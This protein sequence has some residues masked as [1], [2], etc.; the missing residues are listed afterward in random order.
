M[1]KA[2][3][4]NGAFPSF[5]EGT[6]MKEQKKKLKLFVIDD[7]D[8]FRA[9]LA[10]ILGREKEEFELAGCGK[11]SDETEE[12]CIA[13][14]PDVLLVHVPERETEGRLHVIDRIKDGVE[15]ARVLVI[16]EAG[17]VN[18]LLKIAAS[19]CD[20][21]V[22]SD[23]SET[24]LAGVIRNL[25]NDVYIFDRTVIEKMLRLEEERQAPKR[26]EFSPRERKIVEMLGEG[27]SNAAIGKELNL[28]SGTVK[29]I[30]SE[31]LKRRHC[32]NRAQLVS[33]LSS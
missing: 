4:K 18:Y 32:K 25:G 26:A 24:A 23:I 9:G 5:R 2:A 10:G 22:H 17:D 1:R 16:A 31:M 30:V 7:R 28:S 29:N 15:G 12:L 27:K 8:I 14:A 6:A 21:Y 19:G 33:V 20:G 13:A 3:M 11:L